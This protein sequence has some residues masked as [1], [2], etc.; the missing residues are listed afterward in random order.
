MNDRI[1]IIDMGTNTFHLLIA[2]LNNDGNILC[3]ERSAVKIGKDG[4]NE[5][6]ITRA[7]ADRA[8][9]A[10]I[11]FKRV[12]DEYGV[13]QIHAFGTSALRNASNSS[14]VV[15]DI[16]RATGITCTIIDGETEAQYIYEGVR[17]SMEM[18]TKKSLIVDI[19]GGSVECIIGDNVA[20]YWKHSFEIGA[21]RLMEKF[22]KHD[23]I[24]PNEVDA[25]TRCFSQE[26]KPLFDALQEFPAHTLIGASG[27]F[28]TLS[29]I[30]CIQENIHKADDAPVTPLTIDAFQSIHE[31]LVTKDRMQRMDIPGMIEM[32]VDM[33]VVASCLVKYILS[34]YPFSNIKVSSYSLK[35][36]VL[37]S[38]LRASR[39]VA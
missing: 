37:A 3:R 11:Q 39:S 25:L 36:G 10:M 38:Q 14:D 6:Y 4:I 31:S 17:W 33:I 16:E 5:G 21:Q 20:V 13:K 32:R 2:D 19:G 18:G 30:Y 27:T 1:A 8:V 9:N 24:A 34:N 15:H 12:I 28:D 22:Q 7:G 35:E 23:P 29:D 26:L